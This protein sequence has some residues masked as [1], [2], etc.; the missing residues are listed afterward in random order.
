M[1]NFLQIRQLIP[2]SRDTNLSSIY[3]YNSSVCIAARLR[4]WRL[5]SQVSISG[6]V[7]GFSLLHNI[8]TCSGAHLASYTMGKAAWG[9]KLIIHLH[10]APR[11]S[12]VELHLHSPHT[13][14]LSSTY[15]IKLWNSFTFLSWNER[16]LA[17]LSF[18]LHG[19]KYLEQKVLTCAWSIPTQNVVSLAEMM[20][21]ISLA[22][23]TLHTDFADQLCCYSKPH[24]SKFNIY[25][26]SIYNT[27]NY[28]SPVAF[29]KGKN[30]YQ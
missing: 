18:L 7:T 15:L 3:A 12:M 13:F 20:P 23:E 1:N 4:A 22:S 27:R 25:R 28:I 9:V 10:L 11:L 29:Y 2:I 17:A 6:R 16:T 5:M 26:S 24:F 14:S 19:R 8:Q 30:G 21:W